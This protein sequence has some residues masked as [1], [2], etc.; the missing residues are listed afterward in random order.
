MTCGAGALM[1]DATGNGARTGAGAVMATR[2]RSQYR[3]KS[4]ALGLAAA[5]CIAALVSS[6]LPGLPA[7]AQ[8]AAPPAPAPQAPASPDP[9][10]SPTTTVPPWDATP[11]DASKVVPAPPPADPSKPKGF[12]EKASTVVAAE[13]TP[14]KLVYANPDGSRTAKLSTVP[15]R[16]KDGSG[17]WVDYD[18]SIVSRADG[19]VGAKAAPQ[20]ATLNRKADGNLATVQTSAGPVALRHPGASPVAAALDKHEAKYPWALSAGRDLKIA[21]TRDGFKESVILPD[22]KAPASYTEELVLPAGASVRQ[23]DEGVEL[24]DR[25]GKAIATYGGGFAYDDGMADTSITPVSVRLVSQKANTATLEVALADPNWLKSPERSFPVTID[26]TFAQSS[27]GQGGMA[28]QVKDGSMANTSLY[29]TAGLAAGRQYDP[30]ANFSY[31]FR[32]LLRFEL[33][34]VLP[35]NATVLAA[36]LWM[37]NVFSGESPNYSCTGYP[38]QAVALAGPFSAATTWNTQPLTTGAPVTSHPFAHQPT[39]NGGGTLCSSAWEGVPVTPIVQS[40]ANGSTNNGLMVRA[41]E[42]DP[43]ALKVFWSP[44]VNAGQYAPFL[45][46]TYDRLP[47]PPTNV[48]ATA[49]ADGTATVNWTLATVPPGGSAVDSYVVLA[50][51]PSDLSYAGDYAV[52]C[53]TCT[54]ATLTNLARSKNYVLGVYPHNGAGYGYAPSNQVTTPADPLVRAGDGPFFSYDTHAINDRLTATVN[55]G[56]GNLQVST[57]DIAIPVVGGARGLGRT[58]NSFALAPASTSK[59]SPL[60]GPAWRFSDAPDRRL[61]VHSDSSVTYLSGGGHATVFAAGTLAPPTGIDASLIKKTD[62]TYVLTDIRSGGVANFRADGLM[63]SEV[64]RNGNTI[65]FTYPS[66]GG[67]PASIAGNAGTAPGN[68]VN[69]TYGGPGGKVS[70]ISQAGGGLSRSV[71]YAYDASGYLYQVTDAAG[72]TTFG[73]DPTTRDL[74]TITDAANHVTR[75]TYDSSRRVKTV[76]RE[77]TGGD[78]VTTYNYPTATQTTVS[79][80]NG[81]PPITHTFTADGRLE[82]SENA[83]GVKTDPHWTADLKVDKVETYQGSLLQAVLETVW[84]LL[85]GTSTLNLTEILSPTGASVTMGG[86]G[87]VPKPPGAT[88]GATLDRL[89]T[90]TKDTMGFETRYGYDPK[91]NVEQVTSCLSYPGGVCTGNEANIEYNPDGT[92]AK[93]YSPAWPTSNPTLYGYTNKQLTSVDPPGADLGSTTATYDGFGRLR[94]STS[95]RGMTTTFTYDL[96][97]RVKVEAHSDASP[98]ITY[99]YDAAGNLL[100]RS[101]TGGTTTYTYDQ[102]NRPLTKTGGLSWTWYPAGNLKTATDPGGT[103]TYLYNNLNRLHQVNEPSGRKTLY[104]YDIFGRRTDTWYNTGSD[105]AYLLNAVIA[106]FNFAAHTEATYD[107][108]GQLTELKTTRASSDTDPAKVIS[109][110]QYGYNLADHATCP[111]GRLGQTSTRQRVT[112]VLAANTTTYCYDPAGRLT[113]AATTGGPTYSYAFD[114]NTNR[115]S[116]PEG[117]HSVN[118]VDQLTDTGFDY[119]LDGNLTAGGSLSALAY[120]GINQT[121]SMTTGGNTTAYTYAGGGQAERTTAGPTT[122][123]HGILGLMSETTGGVGTYYV[124]DAGGS[125]IYEKTPVGDFYYVYDGQGSVIALVAPDGTQRAAYSYDPYGDHATAT[126]MNGALPPNPW[127]WSGSYM[128]ATGLYKMGARYYDATLGRF[129]QVDPVEGGSANDYDYANGDPINNFDLAG[130]YCITGR[131]GGKCRKWRDV[132][133]AAS[134]TFK[135]GGITISACYGACFGFS[136]KASTGGKWHI[137][138]GCCGSKGPSATWSPDYDVTDHWDFSAGGCYVGCSGVTTNYKTNEASPVI[139]V[140]TPGA[141]YGA[142]Y[143]FV[144]ERNECGPTLCPQ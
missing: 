136:H 68:T 73:Y 2:R 27:N 62:G 47:S 41:D 76:R 25:A 77:I 134:R 127:R 115:T 139:G 131:Q 132:P 32:S 5:A 86:H 81:N 114:A 133:S 10:L 49:N 71:S 93:A 108:A 74:I 122:A 142:F 138:A 116:G 17:K 43:K 4:R 125:L 36:D 97:D 126:G 51:N 123:L 44:A 85:P 70:A 106:P 33:A 59:T 31:R 37:F 54:A 9:S 111:E 75:F 78:A 64:D 96:A 67:Y 11:K 107:A 23:T 63:T 34:S 129:T 102:A 94:T 143:S 39:P 109:H 56:T 135:E 88:N 40:W 22:A 38:V 105:I 120:N 66:G 35:A 53:A 48:V 16:F 13:T 137:V 58:Y 72:T 89:P 83:H 15:Q 141:W 45:Y 144:P 80:A 12:D 104:G 7:S 101:D 110:L 1:M 91:G 79:D 21:L 8:S 20:A 60:F 57:A 112:D 61:L 69:I 95:G 28:T 92:V 3:T 65:T 46:V 30:G 26:P 87:T 14:T 103:T 18:L 99:N 140:G 124:R 42:V 19:S 84:T 52:L 90:W 55:V 128:D 118:L 121:T 113:T 98:S 130:T 82:L 117:T 119:D 29:G 50:L 100:S 6:G 24:I